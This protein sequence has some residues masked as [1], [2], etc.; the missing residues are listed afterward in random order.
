LEAIAE[1]LESLASLRQISDGS[2]HVGIEN[3]KACLLTDPAADAISQHLRSVSPNIGLETGSPEHMRRVGKCGSPEDIVHA[4]R[5]ARAH[6]MHPFVYLIYGLPGE[7]EETVRESIQLMREISDEGVE[8]IILYGFRPLPGSA[9]EHCPPSSV[10]NELGRRM[11]REAE[12]IN[13]GNKV[14]Y[15]GLVIRGIAAEPSWAKHGHTMVYPLDE[16]PVVTIQGGYSPGTLLNVRVT[17]V[18]SPGLVTGE[19]VQQEP[20]Q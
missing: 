4:V 1:L 6:G 18:L 9:F 13:R 7:T 3:M 20:G 17:G 11:R 16:G 12:R 10:E 5:V 14:R 8:R 2:A 15:V 19:V